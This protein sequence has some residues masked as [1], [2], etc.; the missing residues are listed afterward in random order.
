MYTILL[1]TDFSAASRHAIAYTQALFGDTAVDFCLLHVCPLEPEMEFAGA[2]LLAERWQ[3]AE[4]SLNRLQQELAQAP[5]PIYHT[6]RT[7][8]RMGEPTGVVNQLLVKETTKFDLVVLGATGSGWSELAGSVATAM[9]REAKTN[10]LVVPDDAPIRPVDRLVLAT[11]YQS[12]IDVQSLRFLSELANRKAASLT[13]LT[14]ENPLGTKAP[15]SELSRQYV[16]RAL[17]SVLTD[18]Y[19]IHDDNVLHGIDAYIKTHTVDLLVMLPHHKSFF[20]VLL[21][22]SVSRSVAFHPSVPLLSLY[23]VNH[24]SISSNDSSALDKIPF[25]TFL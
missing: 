19:T 9:V 13:L 22:K 8:L 11:D 25:A 2:T 3:T 16:L 10:V 6:Y 23:D 5:E 12:I 15:A 18:T 17:E 21:H 7:L 1:L 14:I 4:A 24:Q 20:D